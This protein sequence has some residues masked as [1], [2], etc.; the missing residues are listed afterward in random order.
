MPIA[1]TMTP[2]AFVCAAALLMARDAR[3]DAP[4]NNA[5]YVLCQEE[6]AE[7]GEECV[8]LRDDFG[9]G[10]A[11]KYAAAL[12]F[13]WRCKRTLYRDMYCRVKKDAQPLDRQAVEEA[14]QQLLEFYRDCRRDDA[15]QCS[16]PLPSALAELPRSVTLPDRCRTEKTRAQPWLLRDPDEDPKGGCGCATLEGFSGT[17]AAL[18]P[19]L[20]LLL[21]ARHQP[22]RKSPLPNPL[23]ATL[24]DSHD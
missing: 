9:D 17:C 15:G 10:E 1:R 18:L 22:A 23:P 2:R 21:A 20:A 5:P 7:P 6:N 14:H 11:F 13:C 3:G 12:G 19:L 24:Q 4:G 16:T 8:F